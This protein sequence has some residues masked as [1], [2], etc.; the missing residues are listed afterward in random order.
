[1]LSIATIR[2]FA[3]F[4]LTAL[5]E[6][7]VSVPQGATITPAAIAI[8]SAEALPALNNP[9]TTTSGGCGACYIIADVAALIWY[10]EV[11][12]NTAA[13][14]VVSILTGNGT[15]A[16]RTSIIQNEAPFTFDPNRMSS[17]FSTDLSLTAVRYDSTVNIGGAILTSPTAYNVFSAYSVT[18]A[19]IVNGQCVTTSGSAIVLPTP[20]SETLASASGRV[21]LDPA[22]EQAFIDYLGF[23]TC[24]GGGEIAS[25]TALV[26]VANV[27][28]TTTRT[29]SSVSLAAAS[30]SLAPTTNPT[31]TAGAGS[32]GVITLT[33]VMS[34]TTVT[35]VLT[36]TAFPAA[37]ATAPLIVVGSSTITPSAAPFSLPAVE[38]SAFSILGSNGTIIP[39]SGTVTG[40]GIGN[41]S[42]LSFQGAAV[43]PSGFTTI[44]WGTALAVFVAV[45][46]LL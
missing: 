33:E 10:S 7:A 18:S 27:T 19:H 32:A 5:V 1:M 29:G 34:S 30:L 41:Y 16:T 28:S 40:T 3:L 26:P 4:A 14:A 15:Q 17:A 39:P 36:G 21:T 44:I 24:V 6:R 12:I 2:S 20:Y 43:K 42:G 13:T 9:I 25:Q 38:P 37:S 31:I 8:G 45:A 23:T 35:A 11:F 22:G 46:G